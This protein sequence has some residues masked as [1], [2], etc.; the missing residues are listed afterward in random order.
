M[1][2]MRPIDRLLTEFD[3]AVRTVL[4]PK[5][6]ECGRANPAESL[7]NA[8]LTPSEKKHVA[9]LMRVNHAGE[10]CAQAL[11][12]GQALTAKL[13]TVREQM[14]SA[15]DEEIDH[16]AWCETRLQELSSHPSVLNAFWYAGSWCIG[17]FA[18]LIG[19]QWSLGFVAETERQVTAHLERHLKHLPAS[20]KRSEA[21]LSQMRVDELA[22][23]ELAHNAGA[24]NLPFLIQRLMYIV[25]NVLTKSSYHL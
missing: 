10:V 2:N 13:D 22:H 6:R 21:I 19:D 24:A 15:A 14:H 1:R 23:A 3:A 8:S 17:A 4:T 11:Y 12:R 18:G 20:D 9:G 5:T 16:L 25:S 7:P